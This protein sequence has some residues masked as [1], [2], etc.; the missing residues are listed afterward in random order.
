MVTRAS[1]YS[2]LFRYRSCTYSLQYTY[3]VCYS[4]SI[5]VDGRRTKRTDCVNDTSFTDRIPLLIG[6]KSSEKV[7][8]RHYC[9]LSL[10]KSGLL[11]FGKIRTKNRKGK[12]VYLTAANKTVSRCEIYCALW[13]VWVILC[14][15]WCTWSKDGGFVC[16]FRF[17]QLFVI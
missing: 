17:L 1:K 9:T 5:F 3:Y 12:N 13:C 6:A 15:Y 7:I 8:T 14:M 2:C 4:A 11:K 16:V 10:W